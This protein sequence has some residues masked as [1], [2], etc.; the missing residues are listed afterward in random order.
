MATDATDRADGTGPPP[1]ATEAE[2]SAPAAEAD[3]AGAAFA[4]KA[5]DLEALRA[6]VIDAASVGA[7]LWL[8]YLFVLFYLAIAVGGV[9]HR[10]L[11]F[12]NP[13]K[14]PFLNVDL[15]L[16]GFFVLGPG[17][18]LIVHAYVLLHFVLLADKVGAFHAELQA[19]IADEDARARLRR[20]L[21]SNIFVQFLA[22][23]REVRTGVMGFLLRLI[24]QISLVIGPLALLVFFQL[25]FLPYHHEAISWWQ[26]IAVVLD[27]ALLWTLWPS[28]ARGETTRLGWRDFRHGRV[29]AWAL[30]S[31][32]PILLVFTIATFP[33][34]WLD[35]GLPAIR[36][37]PTKS[38]ASKWTSEKWSFL[39]LHELLVQ[40]DVDFVA[41]KPTS[42]WSNRLVLPG[43]DVSASEGSAEP[44]PLRGRRLEGA[45]FIGARLSKADFTAAQLQG[46]DLTEAD[47]REAKFECGERVKVGDQSPGEPGESQEV[48]AQLQ[49]A[50]L[51]RAHLQHASLDG[52]R[53]QDARLDKAELQ[54]ASLT[55][56]HL[57]G[58]SL[59]EAQLQGARLDNAR[60][61]GA[62][63][64]NA[65]LQAASL[66]HAL[67]AEATL[68]G[69]RLQ[70]A[71]L[72]GADFTTASLA[73]AHLEGASL[74]YS[75]L[76]GG[77]LDGASLQG[78]SLDDAELQGASLY[79]AHLEG[80]SLNHAK[81]QGVRF[82]KASLQGAML[83][84]TQL[85]GATEL[86][87]IQSE[88]AIFSR[89]FAWRASAPLTG[90]K[91]LVEEPETGP[92]HRAAECPFGGHVAPHDQRPCE[93][94]AH[95][96]ELLRARI[97]GLPGGEGREEALKRIEALD[98]AKPQPRE[99]E[100]AEAWANLA[101]SAPAPEV[102]IEALSRTV[103]EAQ[104]APYVVQGLL[105]D[106]DRRF[107]GDLARASA[108]AATFLD[109]SQCAGARGLTEPEKAKLQ[110]IRDRRPASSSG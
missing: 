100:M 10:N 35:A 24:A 79:G 101:R 4:K 109:E 1:N 11:L 75:I 47:L 70:G 94:S 28:V 62:F 22:G 36:M 74:G 43:I 90:G 45:V 49:E 95:S 107:E 61:D 2:T 96:F 78:A 6:A 57:R 86:G 97:Q 64:T 84:G 50:R 82:P 99:Q 58:V 32:V 68:D 105:R 23:P 87:S 39:S 9:T 56:A 19:Q 27:L 108:L 44:L 55:G 59:V 16:V 12:K 69:A 37:V 34:E 54:G 42:L 71:S 25:Q 46:A 52:A 88:G 65:Q 98:P 93:W 103:C 63:L 20:Q 81:L 17:I 66:E 110:K 60:L 14:L 48:C 3:N 41:R 106:I 29:A 31:L 18:F 104:G 33:R 13:V 89:V 77:R 53:L 5:K 73:G 15:P 83:I 102:Y 92:K 85:Q 91:A 67:L 30:A 80:A 38:P 51:T 40:G 72:D 76:L 8:S 7:G 21:P 26:R